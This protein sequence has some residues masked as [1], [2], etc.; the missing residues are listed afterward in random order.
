MPREGAERKTGQRMRTISLVH[1]RA[2]RV[3]RP[4]SVEG[5]QRYKKIV[6]YKFKMPVQGH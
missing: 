5:L 1:A 6:L 4:A 3:K 2:N